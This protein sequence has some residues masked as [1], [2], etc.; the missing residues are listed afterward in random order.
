MS[1]DPVPALPGHGILPQPHRILRDGP[2]VKAPRQRRQ[3]Q[4]TPDRTFRVGTSLAGFQLLALLRSPA[5]LNPRQEIFGTHAG[6]IS[7]PIGLLR[8]GAILADRVSFRLKGALRRE[9]SA[10]LL[11]QAAAR[12]AEPWFFVPARWGWAWAPWGKTPIA[13]G[14]DILRG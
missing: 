6:S 3:G 4:G 13:A 12:P 10:A 9:P 8:S 5:R 7:G 14:P 11:S 1:A 2:S